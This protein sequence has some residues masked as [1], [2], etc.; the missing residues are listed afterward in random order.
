MDAPSEKCRKCNW[1]TL[2]G[3]I[4]EEMG[5]MLHDN[6]LT[7]YETGSKRKNYRQMYID[8]IVGCF[9]RSAHK[10]CKEHWEGKR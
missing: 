2:L 4:K 1:W 10:V 7:I 5:I 8:A 3:E 6:S 9:N